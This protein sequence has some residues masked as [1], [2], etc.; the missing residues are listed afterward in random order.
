[1]SGPDARVPPRSSRRRRR[2]DDDHRA[3][4]RGRGHLRRA[5]RRVEGGALTVCTRSIRR[6]CRRRPG[7]AVDPVY[8]MSP[9]QPGALG[10]IGLPQLDSGSVPLLACSGWRSESWH[11]WAPLFISPRSGRGAGRA[12]AP[13]GCR[14]PPAAGP[15]PTVPTRRRHHS[16]IGRGRLHRSRRRP[17]RAPNVANSCAPSSFRRRRAGSRPHPSTTPLRV[18][19][20]AG[21]D[22]NTPRD[23]P[24]SN[25][26]NATA[27]HVLL[28]AP[29]VH[30]SA[31]ATT[32][33]T[34]T[35]RDSRR[36]RPDQA[37][38]GGCPSPRPAAAR[39]GCG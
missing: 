3:Y 31:A 23:H 39:R 15:D 28:L 13:G 22:T 33:P 8:L 29:G 14:R 9:G 7:P 37:V 35:R 20:G 18:G 5:G 26:P 24:P 32:A 27:A 16:A 25:S 38:V 19:I 10:D 2:R 11:R 21:P 4:P 1:M 34:C 30:A 36:R 6:S 17:C 12:A